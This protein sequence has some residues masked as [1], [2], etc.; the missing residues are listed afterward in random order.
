[1]TFSGGCW[2]CFLLE[3]NIVRSETLQRVILQYALPPNST[4]TE[5]R[6]TTDPPRPSAAAVEG[7][8]HVPHNVADDIDVA[9][10]N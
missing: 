5:L 2:C 8:V 3:Q 10:R 9:A 4:A 1:M 6:R 7:V